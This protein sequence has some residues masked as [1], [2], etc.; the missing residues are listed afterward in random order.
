MEE[1]SQKTL[2]ECKKLELKLAEAEKERKNLQK[3]YEQVGIVSSGVYIAYCKIVVC[4]HYASP[5][6]LTG[7]GTK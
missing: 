4:L 5:S 1:R 3:K 6:L 2:E 7:V